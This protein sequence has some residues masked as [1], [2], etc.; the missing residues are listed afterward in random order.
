M[1]SRGSYRFRGTTRTRGRLLSPSSFRGHVQRCTNAPNIGAFCHLFTSQR[2]D[3]SLLT[4]SF[5]KMLRR[6]LRFIKHKLQ[7]LSAWSPVFGEPLRSPELY[8]PSIISQN[9]KK[10]FHVSWV[11]EETSKRNRK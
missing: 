8:I 3:F 11:G 2:E 1:L 9:G 6:D 7:A 5:S 10:I 4:I